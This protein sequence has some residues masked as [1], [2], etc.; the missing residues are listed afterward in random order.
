MTRTLGLALL[1]GS[2]LF[3]AACTTDDSSATTPGDD[4]LS[5]ESNDGEKADANSLQDTFGIYTAQKIGAFECNGAGSCTHVNLIRAGRSTTTCIDGKSSDHC[6]ARGMDFTK[7]HLSASQLDDVTGKLQASAAT[8]EIGPQ[9]LVRGSFVHGSNPIYPGVDWVTFQVTELW[10]AQ[11]KDAPDGGTLVMIRDNGR[12]CFEPPCAATNENRLNSTRNM[13]ID[14]LDWPVEF[15][16]IVTSPGWLP[17]KVGTA[18]TKADGVIVAGDRT[19][20]TIMH[21]PTTLRSVNQVF[22]N[23]K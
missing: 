20:G 19:H 14:G 18:M 13:N 8:P 5:G 21:L 4:E 2:S 11:I 3:A 10:A 22:L 1:F 7:L 6:E 16:K 17:N 12:R 9:L 23:I 15:Q